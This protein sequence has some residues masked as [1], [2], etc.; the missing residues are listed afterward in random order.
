MK[1]Q[2]EAFRKAEIH[3]VTAKCER[4][5]YHDVCGQAKHDAGGVE[6]LL[7][8]Q[9]LS[10]DGLGHYSMDFAQQIH[11]PSNT[12]PSISNLQESMGLLG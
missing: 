4:E 2:T 8:K 12:A 5:F 1:K 10:F 9:P 11:F 3:L 7:P 6:V